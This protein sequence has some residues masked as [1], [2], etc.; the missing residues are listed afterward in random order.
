M[1]DQTLWAAAVHTDWLE[2]AP[3]KV[4]FEEKLAGREE[5]GSLGAGSQ[6][7]GPWG[8]GWRLEPSEGRLGVGFT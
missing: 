4:A 1:Q 7:S 6:K 5:H 3:Q 2:K 8:G